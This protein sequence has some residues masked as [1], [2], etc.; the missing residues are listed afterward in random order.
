MFLSSLFE[1][2][3]AM[4]APGDALPGRGEPIPTATHHFVNG[5]PLKGPWP[6]GMEHIYFGMGCFW[7][8]ERLF[9][10]TEGVHVTAA[11]LI[12]QAVRRKAGDAD[13]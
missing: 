12:E 1:K 7:G 5:N 6:D 3:T 8:A 9:W 13:G 4:P 11:G 2:K 10:K